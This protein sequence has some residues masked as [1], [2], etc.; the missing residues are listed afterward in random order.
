MMRRSGMHSITYLVQGN[1]GE[2]ESASDRDRLHAK[3]S[4]LEV[5]SGF[6][7]T[8][9]KTAE[10]TYMYVGKLTERV[11]AEFS[12][13]SVRDALRAPGL[14]TYAELGEAARPPKTVASTWARMLCHIPHIT[15]HAVENLAVHWPTP[16]DF[17]RALD[18][19][20]RLFAED[21]L[22][23]PGKRPKNSERLHR[24]FTA[25]SYAPAEG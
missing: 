13:L 10:L 18:A 3:M 5:V 24:F 21:V 16:L 19:N 14:V 23:P 25:D 17:F 2:L 22:D 7:V 4:E 6:Q 12:T 11:R 9:T 1:L 20:G 8:H 15:P